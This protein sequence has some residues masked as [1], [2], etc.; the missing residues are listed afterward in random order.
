GLCFAVFFVFQAIALTVIAKREGYKNRWMAFV[1]FLSTYYI[2]VCAQKNKVFKFDTKKVALITAI[3]EVVLAAA[4]IVYFVAEY[5]IWDYIS[6]SKVYPYE[7]FMPDFYYLQY[8]GIV[9]QPVSLDWA[10]Y[11]YKYSDPVLLILDFA[12]TVLHIFLLFSFFKTYAPR[13][14]M[15]FAILS[16]FFPIKGVLFY[17]VRKN[18]AVNFMEYVRAEQERQYRNRQQYYNS[19]YAGRN[20]YSN[21]ENQQ[22]G[23]KNESPFDEFGGSDKNPYDND[24]TDVPPDSNPFDDF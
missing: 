13:K 8:S 4:F 16:V 15:L 23:G 18:K 2:G 17:V 20:P 21:Y 22:N 19:F 9:G 7:N 5:Y 6:F 12:Y 11:I 14:H 3:I 24:K 1:P 10:A